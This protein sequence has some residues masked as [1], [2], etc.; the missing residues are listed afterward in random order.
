MLSG[1]SSVQRFRFPYLCL[2]LC[3]LPACERQ[4]GKERL[5]AE[6]VAWV[7][8]WKIRRHQLKDLT[9]EPVYAVQFVAIDAKGKEFPQGNIMG[10][11]GAQAFA[12]EGMIRLAIREDG[13]KYRYMLDLSGV[14]IEGTTNELFSGNAR[15]FSYDSKIRNGDLLLAEVW[16][17]EA[18]G[19]SS[20]DQKTKLVLRMRSKPMP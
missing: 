4:S 15:T 10:G 17:Q 6:D 2:V 5:S 7:T 16:G 8:G 13:A 20:G 11:D 9:T 19:D 18:A 1:L 3:A 14:S 12:P